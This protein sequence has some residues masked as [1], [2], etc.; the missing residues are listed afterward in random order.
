[1]RLV[2]Y[3]DLHA[4]SASQTTIHHQADRY[5]AYVGHHGGTVDVPKPVNRLTGQPEYSGTSIVDV[6]DPAQPRYLAHI[7]GLPG[8]YEEG[9]A[10]MVRV[11]DGSCPKP[12]RARPICCA[13][14]AAVLMK[15]GT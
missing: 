7:P 12:M 15:C 5:I 14:S 2:G 11:C 6:S 9:G 8:E 10:Q 13:S 4:R 3:N 1:M